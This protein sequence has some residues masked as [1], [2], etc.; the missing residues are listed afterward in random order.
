MMLHMVTRC[1][2][3]SSDDDDYSDNGDDEDGDLITI[4]VV[5]M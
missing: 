1:D 3:Q 5:M 4:K 2:D